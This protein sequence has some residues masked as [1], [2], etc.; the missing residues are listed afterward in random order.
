MTPSE[1]E[2]ATWFEPTQKR[3]RLW[4]ATFKNSKSDD[5][6]V[7]L[8][9]FVVVNYNS[10]HKHF[11]YIRIESWM[12]SA[13]SNPISPSKLCLYLQ[14]IMPVSS[15]SS[16]ILTTST[17]KPIIMHF[18]MCICKYIHMYIY[19]YTYIYIH[20]YIYIYIHTYIYIYTRIYIYI[21]IYIYT[22]IH[23]YIYTYIHIY[24]YTYI[25]I[26]IYT[27]IHIY[28]YIHI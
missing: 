9:G 1:I 23:I 24:I 11:L 28:I 22:Y 12:H 25:H 13:N 7:T 6:F 8:Q 26:Y 4:I 19:I 17:V 21:Y 10:C 20:M 14:L 2:P 18:M 16:M 27:Y 5:V 3:G 15:S